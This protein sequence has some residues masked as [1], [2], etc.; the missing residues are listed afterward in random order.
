MAGSS[1]TV[2]KKN[3]DQIDDSDSEDVPLAVRK[4]T[5]TKEAANSNA[6]GGNGR[7]NSKPPNIN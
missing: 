2:S 5:R 7:G 4:K 1:T 6:R 3:L